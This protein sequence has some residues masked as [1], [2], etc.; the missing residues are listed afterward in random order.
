MSGKKRITI[1]S[2][3]DDNGHGV[4]LIVNGQVYTLAEVCS[5]RKLNINTVWARRYRNGWAWS[6]ALEIKDSIVEEV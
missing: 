4:R 1:Q 3:P 2:R 6:D 5:A